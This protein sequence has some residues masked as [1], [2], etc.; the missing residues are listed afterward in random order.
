MNVINTLIGVPLGALLRLCVRLLGSYGWAVILFTL[1]TKVILFPLSVWVQKNS[2]KMVRIKPK[3]NEIEAEF[4]GDRDRISEMQLA[5]YKSEHY[6]PM[7]GAVPMLIQIPIILGLISAVYNPLQHILRLDSALIAA[8]VTETKT[9]LNA[10]ELGSGAQIVVMQLVKDPAYAPLFAAL[11][12]PGADAAA[13]VSAIQALDT[14]FLG[15]DLSA[16]PRLFAGDALSLV[17]WLAGASAFLLSWSQNQVNVLQREAGWLGRW[18][19]AIFLTLFSLYFAAVVPAAVGVYWIAGNLMAIGVML[20]VNALIPPKKYID[21]DALALSKQHLAEARRIQNA[22]KLS[23]AD[24]RRSRADYQRFT[25]AA[26]DMR[27]VFYSESS[28]FYKYFHRIIEA[29]LRDSDVTIHYVTSDP[30]DAVF[31]RHDERVVPYFIDN[32]RLITLFML[33]EADIVVMTMPDLQN[34]HLKRS[35]MRKDTEYIYVY[36]AIIG[37]LGALRD[38]ALDHYDTIFCGEANQKREIAAYEERTG[39]PKKTLVECGYGVIEDMREEVLKRAA[40]HEK[41]RILIAPSWQPDNI[42]E[43]CLETVLECLCDGKT[44]VTIRPHPQYIRRFGP[45]LEEIRRSVERFLGPDCRFELDFSSN[46]TVYTA[47]ILMTDWSTIAFEYAFS[48]E[49]PVL[50]IHTTEK[51][52]GEASTEL[53]REAQLDVTLRD[54]VGRD[55]RPDTLRE[56]LGAAVEDFTT[57]AEDYARRIRDTRDQYVYHF[58]HSGEAGAAYIIRRL[59][60]YGEARKKAEAEITL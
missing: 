42:L 21:Y 10:Q 25:A 8:F 46:E 53:L 38:H 54:V 26:G 45:R 5:L 43:S 33:I 50:F 29:L 31:D 22:K 28:G 3:L 17:P 34:Y 16:T 48:T 35:Y 18:G 19:M 27:L 9:L 1:F 24:R 57:H 36:H 6:K 55:L 11:R 14:G 59:S 32:N 23:R 39:A 52:V 15:L 13:A 12:V 30:R 4:A 40:P 41:R 47:D 2:I 20:L 58:G 51:I 37:G 49:R 44:D 56:T 7:A 60:E